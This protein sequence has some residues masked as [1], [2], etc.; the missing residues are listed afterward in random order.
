MPKDD[1]K[2]S[3][4][5]FPQIGSEAPPEGG[6]DFME[7]FKTREDAE[8]GIG[9]MKAAQD[10]LTEELARSNAHQE[11]MQGMID[12]LLAGQPAQP[13]QAPAPTLDYSKLPDPVEDKD[14]F[15][16]GVLEQ[17][18]AIVAHQTEAANAATNTVQS[19]Q[20][21][22]DSLWD[23]FQDD[24][25]DLADYS[26]YVEVAA[27]EE[28]SKARARGIDSDQLIFKSPDR[29]LK[30]VADST[31]EKVQKL[32]AR[33]KKEPDDPARDKGL[34]GGSHEI[35]SGTE[36]GSKELGSMTQDLKKVQKESGFF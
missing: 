9:E 24:Y 29:F 10:K 31:R 32:E 28:V 34:S 21:Q 27:R 16:R 25:P 20:R 23:K 30:S 35:G 19:Q 36:A 7:G 2:K 15:A 11:T 17:T 4:E 18:E 12:Q 3:P 22:L 5:M 13:L 8:K 6:D 33:F 14:G 26:E 1:D